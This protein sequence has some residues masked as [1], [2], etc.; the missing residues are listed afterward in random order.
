MVLRF[1]AD[2][3]NRF[4]TP[5]PDPGSQ[6]ALV[7]VKPFPA[8]VHRDLLAADLGVECSHGEVEV[9]RGLGDIEYLLGFRLR[10][11]FQ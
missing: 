3:R 10:L 1:L 4:L 7:E 6:L 2:I 9:G 11:P 5:F 8:L